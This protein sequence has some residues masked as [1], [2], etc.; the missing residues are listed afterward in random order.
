MMHCDEDSNINNTHEKNASVPILTFDL[1]PSDL[2]V[3]L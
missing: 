2:S 3:P 1:C